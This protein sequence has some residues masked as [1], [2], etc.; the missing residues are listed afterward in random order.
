MKPICK[1]RQLAASFMVHKKETN[2]ER[3]IVQLLV[4]NT[5]RVILFIHPSKWSKTTVS[6]SF[7]FEMERKERRDSC[8]ERRVEIDADRKEMRVNMQDC[9]VRFLPKGRTHPIGAVATLVAAFIS[10]PGITR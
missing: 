3:S 5:M 9:G 1:W 8:R 4:Y 10:L 6:A 7:D 2:M